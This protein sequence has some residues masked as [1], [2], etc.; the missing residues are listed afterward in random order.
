[1]LTFLSRTALGVV[2]VASFM[3]A[4]CAAE[5][6]ND[7]DSQSD[8]ISAEKAAGDLGGSAV[9]LVDRHP[10]TPEASSIGIHRW[11]VYGL[12]KPDF[13]GV[14]SFGLDQDGDVKIA[15]LSAKGAKNNTANVAIV[16]YD[17]SGPVAPT[18]R[19]GEVLRVLSKDLT[20]LREVVA[21]RKEDAIIGCAANVALLALVALAA[22]AAGAQLAAAA[23]VTAPVWVVA[24]VAGS[25]VVGVAGFVKIVAVFEGISFGDTTDK[26]TMDCRRLL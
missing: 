10:S 9:K 26:L 14:V 4:G 11:T 5:A 2:L 24:G 18:A 17:K 13:Q 22:V 8:A 1:M 12:N 25:G 3:T 19:D 23:V 6:V 20:K 21:R 15:F 7:G 16:N